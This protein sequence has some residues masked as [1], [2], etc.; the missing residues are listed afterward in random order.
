[1]SQFN[2]NNTRK[3]TI[4]V[5]LADENQTKLFLMT[6]TKKILDKLLNMEE[7]IK[8]ET[9]ENKEAMN[10]LYSVCAD[11]LNRNKNGKKITQ[12]QVEELL[13]FEDII[14]FFEAYMEFVSNIVDEKN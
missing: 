13:D 9:Q 1:M 3:K 8:E 7:L 4:T 11:I 12:A 14:Q 6:P 2:F 10:D 5:T